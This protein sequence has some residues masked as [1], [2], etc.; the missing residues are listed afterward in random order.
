MLNPNGEKIMAL[1]A[2]IEATA[3]GKFLVVRL[4]LTEP[5]PSGSGKTLV[6]ASSRGPQKTEALYNGQ[7]IVV[8]VNAYFKPKSEAA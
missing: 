7:P 3:E 6:V 5:T 8:G 4:P 2:K 1:S